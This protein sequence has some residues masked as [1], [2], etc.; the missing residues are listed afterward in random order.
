M[1]VKNNVVTAT[2]R[3]VGSS[4]SG[5]EEGHRGERGVE[6]EGGGGGRTVVEAWNGGGDV[7]DAGRGGATGCTSRD[8]VEKTGVVDGG[9]GSNVVDRSRGGR[10]RIFGNDEGKGNNNVRVG[11]GGVGSD[12]VGET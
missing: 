2:S 11:D 1:F 10:R 5:D 8:A 9:G 3:H 12:G 4:T 7:H 6:G